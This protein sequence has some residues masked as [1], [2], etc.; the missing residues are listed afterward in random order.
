MITVGIFGPAADAEVGALARRLEHRG[1]RAWIVDLAA[2]PGRLRITA[3]ADGIAVDGRPLLEMDAAYLR[4][5]G[6]ALPPH[7]QYDTTS[8]NWDAAGWEQLHPEALQAMAAER[9]AHAV[10]VAAVRSLARQRTVIN[11]PD[12]QN[13]HRLKVWLFDLLMRH[14]APVPQL[15]AGSASG[16]LR[17]FARRAAARWA[18]AVDKPMAGI[19]KTLPWSEAGWRTHDWSR[20]PALYQRLIPG[21]T[22]RAFV[23]EGRLLSAARIVHGGTVD[24]SM[25]QTGIET[26]ELA[27]EAR[28]VAEGV[29]RALDLAF[30]GMDL[31]QDSTTGATL[32]ID[33]NLSPMFVNYGKLSR[34]DVAGH[35][36]ELLIRRAARREPYRR[37]Q[38]LD[39]VDQ[40]KELL[41]SDPDIARLLDR[42][43]RDE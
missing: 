6:T 20:R 14:G 31:M 43:R 12:A 25:S 36:A 30:C 28:V 34:C 5:V 39:R 38:V 15:A 29:A 18:G 10:R 3:D 37:P 8:A 2:F 21:D 7:L 22:V 35:L 24:S 26:I 16:A 32:I 11:P 13:L 33:C 41:A 4:R 40:A 27:P 9:T 23:L 19:Y 17:D 42:P 1:A